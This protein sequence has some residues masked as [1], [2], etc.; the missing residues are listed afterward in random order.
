MTARD[1]QLDLRGDVAVARF[2]GEIDL[3]NA[4]MV[5]A[6]ILAGVPN[7]AIGLVIDLSAVEYI[8]SVGLRMLFSVV[9][10]LQASRQAVAIA[11]EHAS[12]IRKL[13][14][15]TAVDEAIV[16]RSCVDECASALQDQGSTDLSQAEP[17]RVD[18]LSS[19]Q[20]VAPDPGDA[21]TSAS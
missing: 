19:I 15:M 20:C 13:L 12:P 18:R 9:R 11:L 8:D 6:Q 14:K 4:P 5:S 16:L 17:S 1:V 10:S 3:A 21:S 2:E 7:D